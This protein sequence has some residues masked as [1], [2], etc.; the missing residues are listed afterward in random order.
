MKY[1]NELNNLFVDKNILNFG[2]FLLVLL[3]IAFLLSL[4]INVDK[5]RSISQLLI[6]ILMYIILI[7][8]NIYVAVFF[9]IINI[10]MLKEIFANIRIYNSEIKLFFVQCISY[11]GL[12]FIPFVYIYNPSL[13]LIIAILYFLLCSAHYMTSHKIADAVLG[14]C[15][16]QLTLLMIFTLSLF[17]YISSLSNGNKF[18]L[19]IF[20]LTNV[21]DIGA[22]LA[23][24][25][26]GKRKLVPT[27]S[28]N[29]TIGGSIGA[30][31]FG[32]SLSVLFVFILNIP[33]TLP[34]AL[35]TGLLIGIFSQV[36]DLFF[37]V[38]KRQIG[39]KDYGTLIPGHGGIID[40][41]DS[42][43]VTLPLFYLVLRFFYL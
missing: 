32:I 16:M 40:R 28:P 37:S 17:A 7:L 29:K 22:L 30:I 19:Y 13:L 36:G 33:F 8:P 6:Y 15:S 3:S 26:F 42:L 9:S 23:G 39:V 24:K 43:V 12:S 25:L 4:K 14:L 31:V 5:K 2:I 21:C 1:L 27:I 38:F 11:I 18:C 34:Q 41:F 20:F 35:I 10:L